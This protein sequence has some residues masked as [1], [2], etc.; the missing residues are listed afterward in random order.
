MSIFAAGKGIPKHGVY[1]TILSKVLEKTSAFAYACLW[2]AIV[3]LGIPSMVAKPDIKMWCDAGLH[4]RSWEFV[5]SAGILSAERL[6]TTIELSTGCEHHFKSRCDS[7]FAHLNRY[8]ADEACIRVVSTLDDLTDLYNRRGQEACGVDPERP[9][10]WA[11]HFTPGPKKDFKTWIMKPAASPIGVS[12]AYH[13]RFKVNDSRRASLM[14]KGPMRFVAT[15][16][17]ASSRILTDCI[18]PHSCNFFPEIMN[19]KEPVPVAK[20]VDDDEEVPIVPINMVDGWRVGYRLQS[21]ELEG[22]SRIENRQKIKT[23]KLQAIAHLVG[24]SARVDI[25]RRRASAKASAARANS[26][27]RRVRLHAK[28]RDD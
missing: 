2:E 19:P 24:E 13:W 18:G 28:T 26:A 27:G 16:I 4:Y 5:G 15:G 6:K 1:V 3:K 23:I 11:S 21:P 20:K 7:C 25:A 17:S 14:G 12:F 9:Q 10:I 8:K 22:P